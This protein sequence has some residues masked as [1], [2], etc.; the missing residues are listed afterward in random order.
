VRT[1]VHEYGGASWLVAG[2]T[3]IFSNFADGRLYRQRSGQAEPE[4]LTPE[5]PSRDRQWR[6]S[7][8]VLD[9]RRRRWIGVREDHTGE[10]EAVNAVVAIDLDQPG[11]LQPG[12][13]PGRVLAGGHDFFCSARLSPDAS[14]MVWLAW[15]HPNMPWTAS[16]LYMVDLD[17]DGM[18]ERYS[19]NLFQRE[20]VYRVNYEW[21]AIQDDL[22][23]G[24]EDDP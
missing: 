21:H 20:A 22:H 4:P 9:Q 24:W 17:S 10:G 13:S 18:A 11:T 2:G 7:D 3:C 6:Y 5:P 14:R 15:D 19:G 1:R 8:G 16:T 23:P 12:A